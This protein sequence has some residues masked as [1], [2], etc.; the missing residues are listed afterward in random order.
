MKTP[1][2]N[3]MAGGRKERIQPSRQRGGL[4]FEV[5]SIKNSAYPSDHTNQ[6]NGIK[7]GDLRFGCHFMKREKPRSGREKTSLVFDQGKSQ[8]RIY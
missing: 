2:R 7:N 8:Q 6:S 1:R 4:A 5:G 3:L